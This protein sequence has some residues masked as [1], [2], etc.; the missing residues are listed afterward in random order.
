MWLNYLSR[1]I[2]ATQQLGQ[3]SAKRRLAP[4]CGNHG[5]CP[6][7]Q[8]A[9]ALVSVVYRSF[10][11]ILNGQAPVDAKMELV[12]GE[13]SATLGQVC[14]LLAKRIGGLGEIGFL[15]ML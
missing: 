14:T 13:K 15:S 2:P 3:R 11:C 4:S 7:R 1:S 5:L 12:N 6:G 10:S 9:L 8:Y